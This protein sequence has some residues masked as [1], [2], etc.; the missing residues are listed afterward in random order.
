MR[1]FIPEWKKQSAT[2]IAMPHK[3]SDWKPYLAEAQSKV[4]EIITQIS[5][6]QKVIVL[7]ENHSDIKNLQ[8]KSNVILLNIS[9]NDSWCRDF[10][11]LT[12]KKDDKFMLIDFIFNAWGAKYAANLDNLAGEKIFAMMQKYDFFAKKYSKIIME[13]FILEGGSIDSNGEILLTTRQCLLS[14][15]RNRLSQSKITQK[16]KK[17]F[18]ARKIIWLENGFLEGDDTDCH[19]D[20]L[21]RFIDKKTIVYLKCYDRFDTHFRALEAMERELQKLPFNLVPLPLPKAIF[22]KNRRLPASYVNFIFANNAM[23]VP[24]FGDNKADKIALA[25]FKKLAKNREIIPI[26][27]NVLIRQG[28]GL[29]CLTMNL[30]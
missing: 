29:H 18:G 21:A 14:K 11:P 27:S 16:L 28:G 15:N 7:Y 22:Y 17:Y 5:R 6:F 24:I 9:L 26:D 20:N 1:T 19:I 10:S 12:F 2:I 30:M 13:N 3:N 4:R 8:G 23:L 25:T